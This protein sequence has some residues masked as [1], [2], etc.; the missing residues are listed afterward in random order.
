MIFSSTQNKSSHIHWW[1][2]RW[3]PG[4]LWYSGHRCFL[5][6]SEWDACSVFDLF[7]AFVFMTY[8]MT[9]IIRSCRSPLN[10]SQVFSLPEGRL[11]SYF[12]IVP[13]ESLL[14]VPNAFLGLCYYTVILLA[15]QFLTE[16][17]LVKIMTVVVNSAAMTSSVFLATKLIQLGELCLLCWTTHLLNFLLIFY[18]SRLLLKSTSGDKK[19]KKDWVRIWTNVF[20]QLDWLGTRM[21]YSSSSHPHRVQLRLL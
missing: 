7:D 21:E 10:C 11:L 14:D 5:Q 6:V 18:Y 3:V 12:G 20:G 13:N 15:E 16:T 1:D 2:W 8:G 19:S 17:H 9:L 4:S